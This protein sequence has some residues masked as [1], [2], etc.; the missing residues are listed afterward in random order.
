M[1]RLIVFSVCGEARAPCVG[2]CALDDIS[3][4]IEGNKEDKGS[5]SPELNGMFTVFVSF[6]LRTHRCIR[7]IRCLP[8]PSCARKRVIRSCPLQR[9]NGLTFQR[10]PNFPRNPVLVSVLYIGER[11]ER[12]SHNENSRK[13]KTSKEIKQ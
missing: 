5:L 7:D 13:A 12:F 8:R 3:R 10:L 11:P 2:D 1:W 6:C 4:L 9:F